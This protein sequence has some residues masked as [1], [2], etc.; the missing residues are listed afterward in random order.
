MKHLVTTAI[1][2]FGLGTGGAAL[3]ADVGDAAQAAMQRLDTDGDGQVTREEFEA[4]DVPQIEADFATLDENGD[5][6][7]EQAEIEQK[8][9]TPDEG[10]AE[11]GY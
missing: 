6:V 7:V 5:G 9:R 11:A 2:A 1:L 3:A 8:I 10:E 4:T